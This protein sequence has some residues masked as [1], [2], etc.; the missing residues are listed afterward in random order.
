MNAR[1]ILA[2]LEGVEEVGYK[3]PNLTP[4]DILGVL[5]NQIG[6]GGK[7]IREKIEMMKEFAELGYEDINELLMISERTGPN[8]TPKQRR[9]RL[10]D[11]FAGIV[12][13]EEL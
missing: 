3:G 11:Y 2:A 12:E 5:I 6:K 8:E 9:D 4:P 1:I 13:A 7:S 10:R